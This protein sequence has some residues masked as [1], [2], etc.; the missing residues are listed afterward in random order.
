MLLCWPIANAI[1]R[2]GKREKNREIINVGDL[3][4]ITLELSPRLFE[5]CQSIYRN[6]ANSVLII[7]QR[8]FCKRQIIFQN[9]HTIF[10]LFFHLFAVLEYALPYTEFYRRNDDDNRIGG[11]TK[12]KRNLSSAFEKADSQ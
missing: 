12:K 10:I 4:K 7:P 11:T 5:N 8:E 1:F 2:C 3:F 6:A 9:R